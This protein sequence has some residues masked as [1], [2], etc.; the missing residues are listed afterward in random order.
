MTQ[1]YTLVREGADRKK[2]R[3]RGEEEN[4]DR[5]TNLLMADWT[6]ENFSHIPEKNESFDY[7]QLR[8]S[9]DEMDHNRILKLRIQLLS[10]EETPEEKEAE[11]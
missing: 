9:I 8:I 3:I 1:A 6:L 4:E 2:G 5:F 7:Y 10:R 11:S